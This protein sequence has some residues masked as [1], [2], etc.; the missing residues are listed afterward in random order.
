M[1]VVGYRKSDFHTKDG[2]EI[3]GYNL[4]IEEPIVSNGEGF[5]C[6]KI[7]LTEAKLEKMEVEIESLLGQEIVISYNRW[8]KVDVIAT[9]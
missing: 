3:K 2:H 9:R 1:K 6:D 8:G 5:Q 4:F 7:Y